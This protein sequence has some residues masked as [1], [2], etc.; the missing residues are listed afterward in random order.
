MSEPSQSVR[1]FINDAYQLIS[2]STPTV[3]L[4]GDDLSKGIQFMNELLQDYSATG[5]MLTVSQQ[6]D[7]TVGINQGY[8]TFGDLSFVPTPDVTAA[9]QLVNLES[10]WLTL[11]GVTY[12]LIYEQRNDFFNA[13]KYDP[14]QGLP[15][16]VIF[17]PETNVTKL[18]IF[19]APSQVYSLSVYGKFRMSPFSS[20][21]DMSS[22]P[23]YY[24]RYLKLAVARDVSYYKGRSEAWTPK[25]EAMYDEAYKNMV[26][27]TSVNLD[28]NINNESWLN[29]AW[30][31]RAGI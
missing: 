28:I 8:I 21:F 9:G 19:P 18:R 30:R 29:G 4:H 17:F 6:V 14:L 7:F 26:A 12:P 25:L 5:Q 22:L 15:R 2:A 3:P 13:Y 27:A 23:F 31:V 11:N 10:A 20:N 1:L 24:L 16:Y